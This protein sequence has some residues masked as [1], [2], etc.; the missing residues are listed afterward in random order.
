MPCPSDAQEEA[1]RRAMESGVS[2]AFMAREITYGAT[3]ISPMLALEPTLLRVARQ[4]G[5]FRTALVLDALPDPQETEI[6]K[7][8]LEIELMERNL[9]YLQDRHS[10]HTFGKDAHQAYIDIVHETNVRLD[11]FRDRLSSLK[12]RRRRQR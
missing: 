9:E 7:L 4:F 3:G 5:T 11:L 6:A 10:Y 2:D 8:E 12:I 1:L